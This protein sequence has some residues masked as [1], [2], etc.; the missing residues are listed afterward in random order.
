MS[1]TDID[2]QELIMGERKS[3]HDISNQLVVAQGMASF[4]LKAAK[5]RQED[6][7]DV[8]KDID[9]LEKTLRAVSKITEIVQERRQ[10]LHSH[11]EDKA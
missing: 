11:S 8:G 5:K 1:K 6:G 3:L 10:L 9:R 7:E 4:V 2:V